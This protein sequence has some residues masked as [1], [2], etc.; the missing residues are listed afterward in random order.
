MRVRKGELDVP[1][2]VTALP[3]QASGRSR[4]FDRSS[5]LSW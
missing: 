5:M 1:L 4:F 2:L 3:E